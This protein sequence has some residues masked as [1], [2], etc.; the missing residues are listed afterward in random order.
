LALKT[1]L[2]HWISNQ[3]TSGAIIWQLNDCWPAISWSIIDSE[4]KPKLAYYFVKKIFSPIITTINKEDSYFKIILNNHCDEA[5]EGNLKISLIE[6]GSGL[7]L[8]EL[9]EKLSSN[10][11][12]KSVIQKL[13]LAE[14]FPHKNLMIIISLYN[15]INDL[16]YRDFYA[17]Q[18]WKNIKLPEMKLKFDI[19]KENDL[20]IVVKS[21][22]TVFFVDLFHPRINFSDRGFILLPEETKKIKIVGDSDGKVLVDEIQA[23]SLNKYLN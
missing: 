3:P 12:V 4:T 6:L 21:K 18:E 10:Y 20:Y 14:L 15:K 19:I 1:C 9:E 2:E 5:F 23:Y 7:I 17:D 16:I 13:L 22:T 8:K 11:S